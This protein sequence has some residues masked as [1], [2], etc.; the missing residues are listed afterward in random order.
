MIIV[1]DAYNL[2]R[3]IPPYKKTITDKERVY[4]IAQLSA[5][6]KRKGHKIVIVFDGGSHEWPFKEHMKTVTVVYSGI[7][8]SADDYI[9]EYMQIHHTQDLLLVS[10]DT[11]LNR[12][13]ERLNIP[14]IDSPAF[15]DL[16]YQE[17]STKKSIPHKNSEAT[18]LH[19]DN[20]TI[21]IDALMMQA[22]K[23]VPQKSEDV[24]AEK[25]Q[26]HHAKKH[27]VSKKE[28]ALLKKLNKL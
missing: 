25:L 23:I 6:G 2:L 10:S 8:E 13:A 28:R 16:L 15:Y 27:E 26:R 5:Y 17:L 18:K 3:S 11:E 1:V 21:D 24:A 20:D 14:S 9:K 12:W 22:S 19:H 4:F 7:H